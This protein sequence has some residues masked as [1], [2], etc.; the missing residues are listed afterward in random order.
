MIKHKRPQIYDGCIRF[1]VGGEFITE[2]FNRGMSKDSVFNEEN[3][4]DII[5]KTYTYNCCLDRF[6]RYTGH[7]SSFLIRRNTIKFG[8]G[9]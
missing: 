5:R 1:I 6:L 9:E 4:N 3:I 8:E 2:L 7:S